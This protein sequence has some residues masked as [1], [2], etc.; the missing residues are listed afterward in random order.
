MYQRCN[1]CIFQPFEKIQQYNL[2]ILWY[3][4]GQGLTEFF[5][6][7]GN[8]HTLHTENLTRLFRL[9]SLAK[10][11]PN[12]EAMIATTKT[13]RQIIGIRNAP[14]KSPAMAL[15]REDAALAVTTAAFRDRSSTVF[16]LAVDCRSSLRWALRWTR[17]L[18]NSKGRAAVFFFAAV[19]AALAVDLDAAAP[20]CR[21]LGIKVPPAGFSFGAKERRGRSLIGLID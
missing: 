6:I 9:A 7:N 17:R 1:F 3:Q 14:P 19:D 11:M 2:P 20:L 12:G 15:I 18:A 21:V 8:I 13:I 5:V 4:M 10:R 16:A